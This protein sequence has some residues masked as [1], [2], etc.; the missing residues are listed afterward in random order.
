MA[1]LLN[2]RLLSY[3]AASRAASGI[4][5]AVGFL[6]LV[7][8]MF[9][10]P[11]LKN[12]LPGLAT[13]KA[14]TALAF[15]LAGLSLW[16]AHIRGQNQWIDR[17]SKACAMLIIL[18]GLLTLSETIFS[19]DLG[20]D[21]LLFRD[22]LTPENAYP[23]RM[24]L[25]TALNFSLLGFSLFLLDRH[26]YRWPVEVF[27]IA[28]LLISVLALMGYAYGVSSLYQFSPYS[29]I[30]SSIAI[31]TALA[32]SI[33]CLGILFARPEQGLMRIFSSENAGGVLARRVVP[34]ALVLPL[35][36][37][38]LL[39]AGQRMGLYDS[40]FRLVLYA[41]SMIIA[42]TI[43]IWWNAS[44]LNQADIQRK[45]AEAQLSESEERYRRFFEN[46]HETFV[47]QEI[48]TDDDGKPIDLRFLDVNPSAERIFGKTRSEIVGRTRSQLSGRPDP[49]GVEMASRVAST[50]IPFHMIRSS[51]GFGGWYESFTY[52]LGPGIVATLSLDITERKKAEEEVHRLNV[53]LEQRVAKRTI[54]LEAANKELEAFS[55]SVSH[56][57]R[58]PLRSID[59]Y[60]QALLEDYSELLPMEGR[61]FLERMRSSAHHMA[62]LID[63]LLKLSQVTRAHISSV[64]VD[65]TRLAENILAELQRTHPERSVRFSVAPNLDVRG[66]PHLLQVVLENL[67]NNAW[68]YTSKQEHAKI[69]FG[70]KHK[71]GETI[72]FVRD[73]G[74]GF[75][76]TYADKLFGAFQRL[77]T[78]TEFPG[79]GI[80]LAS[81]QRIIHR[82]G[83]RIWAEA[84]VGKGATFFFTLPTLERIKPEVKPM[85]KDSLVRRVQ[86]II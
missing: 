57:L 78:T 16:L 70:S 21:Q 62:E 44:L 47:I 63:D 8:W 55:Y 27:T 56:D 80:G 28:A 9:D 81:V 76:M 50:G 13:M 7:G 53:E 25:V 73:N 10:I 64:P 29:S 59:G 41:L 11:A 58:A 24:S 17:I 67:L 40:T 12:I 86:E 6:V 2:S 20:I 34:A 66:D 31:H 54:E 84:A 69:E 39:L 43:L 75:D 15:M 35:L 42:F 46:M 22:A 61:K 60:S 52:S 26:H 49:E 4:V 79:T 14:N 71:N 68:K 72:Y 32:F 85:E 5:F 77:H 33:L 36:L 82:H 45:R 38:W 18:I 1:A 74:A 30:Y 65:L 19:R 51:P 23:G 3:R 48:V 37:G 83:G